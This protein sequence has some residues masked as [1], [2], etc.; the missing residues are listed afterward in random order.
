[1]AGVVYVG[2]M[3]LSLVVC[4]LV[5]ALIGTVASHSAG[6]M[7]VLVSDMGLGMGVVLVVLVVLAVFSALV[8]RVYILGCHKSILVPDFSS[9]LCYQI[10]GQNP[11]SSSQETG[12]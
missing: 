7:G 6:A 3:A 4:A 11:G 10:L 12:F 8:L 9:C 1:V 2:T 5:R